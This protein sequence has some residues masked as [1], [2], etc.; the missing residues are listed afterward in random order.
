MRTS[1]RSLLCV[2]FIFGSILT[3]WAQD[4]NMIKN[5]MIP[6]FNP[7]PS[8]CKAG[9]TYYLSTSSFQFWP[10]L[11]IYESK[12]LKNWKL[13]DY[14]LKETRQ[15]NL[16]RISNGGGIWA[17]D[18]S[19]NEQ[20]DL[21]YIAYTVAGGEL[22]DHETPNYVATSRSIHG[23]WSDPVYLNSRGND[24]AMFHDSDGRHWYVCSDFILE[25]RMAPHKGMFM[26]EYDPVQKKLVGP[27]KRI[28]E[29]TDLGFFEGSKMFK[30]GDWYYLVAAEGGTN[31]G[32]AMTMARSKDIWGPYEVHPDNPVLTALGAYSMIKRA[33]HG[34][35]QDV[36]GDRAVVIYLAGRP[37]E[38]ND[39]FYSTMGRETFIANAEWHKD[40]WL[41]LDN[42]SPQNE[43]PMLL[44]EGET[45]VVS[46]SD[47]FDGEL[48]LHW[49]SLRVPLDPGLIDLKS[50]PGTL[51]L[52]GTPSFIHSMDYPSILVQR[53]RHHQYK[54]S[55]QLTFEPE[56]IQ[57]EAGLVV[58]YDSRRWYYFNKTM[59]EEL[60]L[61]L[62]ISSLYDK[63]QLVPLKVEG[64][65]E[66]EIEC[67]GYDFH[68]FYKDE[69]QARKKIG[70]R[71][72]LW[73]SDE[74]LKEKGPIDY[75]FTG[76]VVGIAVW[77]HTDYAPAAEFG[78]FHYEGKDSWPDFV[79][80]KE[81]FG[82]TKPTYYKR[83]EEHSEK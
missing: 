56:A 37:V 20:E 81:F 44:P 25:P 54:I 31:Y 69:D 14:V 19:Y 7:D 62:S 66:L 68:F 80:N 67:D 32:H 63:T 83:P 76:T 27:H 29:G 8:I 70:T 24:P 72:A 22:W 82:P 71:N 47:E 75:N 11:P 40:G 30:R 38:K 28:F 15:A 16:F 50:K 52:K 77:D 60:G 45:H 12:D 55:T 79:K 42:K 33:G 34:D 13:I 41:Y 36:S 73:L 3:S 48:S 35:I 46:S 1:I 9:D 18:L 6:G 26:Q 49:N 64:S 57:Q 4:E 59:D 74:G 5:A 51:K 21:F 78:Y 10:G 17:P 43:V 2:A 58:Y 65:V 53:V 23:P 39:K 61:C